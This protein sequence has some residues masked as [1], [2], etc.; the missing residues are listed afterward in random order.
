[1]FLYSTVV[2]KAR[3]A[4]FA[5]K[6]YKRAMYRY[7]QRILPRLIIAGSLVLASFGCSPILIQYEPAEGGMLAIP[8]QSS[9]EV[10]VNRPGLGRGLKLPG[11]VRS[12]RSSIERDIREGFFR[13]G[14]EPI[15]VIVNV[16]KLSYQKEN[17]GM[18]NLANG[19]GTVGFI[20]FLS[21]GSAAPDVTLAGLALSALGMA[22]PDRKYIASAEMSVKLQ[23]FDGTLIGTYQT[24]Q[25]LESRAVSEFGDK[26]ANPKTPSLGGGVLSEVLKASVGDIQQRVQRDRETIMEVLGGVAPEPVAVSTPEAQF[27]EVL[28]EQAGVPEGERVNIAV[29]EL[30]AYGISEIEVQALTN[31]LRVELF[32]TGR[33]AVVERDQMRAIMEEQDF[34]QTGCTTNECLVEV[35]QLLNVQQIF[36]GSISKLGEVF[37]I[38]VRVID[39][40][41]GEIVNAAIV[42]VMGA[43]SDVLTEGIGRAAARLAK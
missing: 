39:V 1:M 16:Q 19:L 26:K 24:I 42:D 18:H 43:I 22:I 8:A 14:R 25:R 40:L 31:R 3:T 20:M 10:L 27:V 9:V 21:G 2:R 35:G 13:P 5:V 12:I 29:V 36:A 17:T 41:T 23:T 28:P 32:Q 7:S 38:E 37:S 4:T 11:T 34:Q 6:S 15:R 33:F 30:E